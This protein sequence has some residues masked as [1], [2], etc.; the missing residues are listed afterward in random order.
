MTA[1]SRPGTALPWSLWR[2]C[3]CLFLPQQDSCPGKRYGRRRR[4]R[5]SACAMPVPR[6]NCMHR[7]S[8]P[9]S[10]C[11]MRTRY[12]P[13]WRHTRPAIFPSTI[14]RQR[15][16]Q[17]AE[18]SLSPPVAITATGPLESPRACFFWS[19]TPIRLGDAL[20]VPQPRWAEGKKK[21][22]LRQLFPNILSSG[23]R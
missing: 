20:F 16:A 1:A 6:A 2:S 11:R 3:R 22:A 12:C 9:F 7:T 15:G 13:R 19:C 5:C 18:S 8:S 23:I 17:A 4:T 21:A 10:I 14:I